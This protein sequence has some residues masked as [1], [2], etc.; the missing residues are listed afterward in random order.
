M[1]GGA[2]LEA[3]PPD[4]PLTLGAGPIYARASTP[5]ASRGMHRHGG[6]C[7]RVRRVLVARRAAFF[8][9]Y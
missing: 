2:R 3:G 1:Y 9:S 4:G 8:T 6:A 5:D 7:Q